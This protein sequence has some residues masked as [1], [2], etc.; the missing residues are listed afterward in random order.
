MS[1]ERRGWA[2][3]ESQSAASTDRKTGQSLA[4]ISVNSQQTHTH[5]HTH[6][7]YSPQCKHKGICNPGVLLFVVV[8][9]THFIWQ[10]KSAESWQNCSCRQSPVADPAMGGPGG[11][12]H[13]T[14]QNVGLVVAMWSSLRHGGKLPF[15]S[16]TFGHF[17]YENGQKAFSFT[18]ALPP[19]PCWELH[20]QTPV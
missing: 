5:T 7:Y 19:D 20:P 16:L 17:L 1:T 4:S 12:P 3:T 10:Y 18:A 15:Q 14:D 8:V 11:R 6:A 9:V 2:D 13:P